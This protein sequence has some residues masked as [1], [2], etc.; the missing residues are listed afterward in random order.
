VGQNSCGKR[1]NLSVLMGSHIPN[2]KTHHAFEAEDGRLNGIFR[3]HNAYADQLNIH[4]T[5]VIVSGIFTIQLFAQKVRK[6]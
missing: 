5:I 4:I 3:L 6:L 1:K 2:Q